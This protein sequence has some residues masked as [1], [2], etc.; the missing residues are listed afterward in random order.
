MGLKQKVKGLFTKKRLQKTVKTAKRYGKTVQKYSKKAQK[1]G[2]RAQKIQEEQFKFPSFSADFDLFGSPKKR[3]SH[4][5]CDI[6]RQN[7]VCLS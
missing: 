3:R 2:K 5:S 7:A 6:Q 4:S 1:Y